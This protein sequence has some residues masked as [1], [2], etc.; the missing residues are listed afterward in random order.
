MGLTTMAA[1]CVDQEFPNGLEFNHSFT[2]EPEWQQQL[3][4]DGDG[5]RVETRELKMP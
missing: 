1:S 5:D 4:L 3:E 2:E